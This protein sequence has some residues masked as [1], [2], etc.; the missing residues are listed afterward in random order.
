MSISEDETLPSGVKISD[1]SNKELEAEA[2]RLMK[3][4]RQKM[5]QQK[6]TGVISEG[7]EIQQMIIRSRQLHLI[8]LSRL[9]PTP[10]A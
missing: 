8:V 6:K 9:A 3:I 1:A 4:V 7:K 2:K 10:Q 5:A